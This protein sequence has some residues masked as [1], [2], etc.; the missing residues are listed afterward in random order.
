[1]L[2]PAAAAAL[3]LPF[4]LAAPAARSLVFQ[5]D[6]NIPIAKPDIISQS[7]YDWSMDLNELRLVQFAEDELAV[8]ITEHDKIRA[9]ADGKNF[10]DITDT[11]SLG[12]SSFLSG[13]LVKNEYPAPGNHSKAIKE[14]NKNLDVS[15][16]RSFLKEFTGFRTRYYRS[17][18]GK[19]SQQFLMSTLQK[20]SSHHKGVEISEFAHTWTQ[21][22]IIARFNPSSED[23]KSAPVVILGAHQ[24]STNAWP[25]LPA[26]G[27]D[28]DGSGTTSMLE[29]FRALATANFT[30]SRPVEFH[31]YS[32]EEGGLLGSQAVAKDYEDRGVKVRGMMHMDMT[33][34]VKKGTEEVAAIMEDNTDP[35]LTDFVEA[36]IV[37]YLSIPAARTKCGY[38]CSDHASFTKAG[39]QAACASESTFDNINHNIH[40]TQDTI[41]HPEFSF[42]HMKEFSKLAVAFAVELG[43]K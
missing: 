20:L 32:A 42:S 1:M 26:P 6:S 36:L 23:L 27:A 24:D 40:S 4:T 9:R 25:F 3:A 13:A 14:I 12:F 10:M 16:M 7:S 31:F 2:V 5:H 18:T 21:S 17:D 33:A 15:S 22:S 30:P 8:W 28:D 39:Y 11:P 37:E 35:A 19:Q 43:S 29:A 38:A 34:W 41:D